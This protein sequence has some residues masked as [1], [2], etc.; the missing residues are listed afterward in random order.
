MP[1]PQ[2]CRFPASPPDI[3]NV[4]TPL[5]A[6]DPIAIQCA[7]RAMDDAAKYGIATGNEEYQR[8]MIFPYFRSQRAYR[9]IGLAGKQLT[10]WITFRPSNLGDITPDDAFQT[11]LGIEI[12][13]AAE[14][15]PECLAVASALYK[16]EILPKPFL[17]SIIDVRARIAV[18]LPFAISG[19]TN[20]QYSLVAF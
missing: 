19:L 12:R 17:N 2:R 10:R 6:L 18:R 8:W 9:Q 5:V 20:K 15:I 11:E 16:I 4:G 14:K 1:S 3:R 13:Q 7:E